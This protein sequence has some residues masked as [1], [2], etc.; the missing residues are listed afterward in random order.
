METVHI[1]KNFPSADP[2]IVKI[3]LHCQL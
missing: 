3:V 1:S 2:G